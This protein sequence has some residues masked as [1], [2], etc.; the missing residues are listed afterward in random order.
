MLRVYFMDLENSVQI[1][2]DEMEMMGSHIWMKLN[3]PKVKSIKTKISR[4][5]HVESDP[6]LDCAVYTENKPYSK[7]ARKERVDLFTKEIV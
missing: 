2:P 6:L 1:D 3:E 4:T 5:V 7:C